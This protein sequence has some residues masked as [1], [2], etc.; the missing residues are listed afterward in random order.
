MS[1]QE[2]AINTSTLR[3]DINE[4]KSILSTTRKQAED[5]FSQITEL[6]TMWD[7]PA[8]ETFN[9]QFRH[10]YQ[11]TINLCKTVESIIECMEYAREQYDLCENEVGS[12]V[13]SISI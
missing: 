8:N 4:L 9:N 7:G 13:D 2:I 12:I 6:D 11:N 1:N 3:S 10:D 5:M